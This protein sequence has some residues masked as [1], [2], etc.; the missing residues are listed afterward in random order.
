MT[1]KVTPM[2]RQYLE[3]KGKYPKFLLFYR[4]GDFYE[5]FNDDA[6]TASSI[7][8]ITLTQRRSSKDVEG[9]PMCG[10]PFH[11]AEGYIAKLVRNGF[12]VALCEQIES[13]EQAKK[14][15]G[16]SA[17]VKR[18]VVRLFTAGTLTEESM[19][20]PTENNYILSITKNG[21]DYYLAWL[22]I[23]AGSF[24]YSK[25]EYNDISAEISRIAPSEIV[26]SESLAEK[27][28]VDFPEIDYNKFTEKYN[29]YFN[30][31]RCEDLI[32][33]TY[34]V[35]TLQGFGI[36]NKGEIIAC[37]TLLQYIYET[38]MRD[39]E[40]LSR[41]TELKN[42]SILHIDAQSRANLEIMKTTRGEVR[43]SLF[44]AINHTLTPFGNRKLQEFLATPLQD[45]TLINH[46]LDAVEELLKKLLVKQ[47]LTDDLK[48][49]GDFER[50]LS[51]IAYDRASPRDLLVIKNSCKLFNPLADKLDQLD[52]QMFKYIASS[53]RGFDELSELLN[54]SILDE[55]LPL[56]ARDGG[57]IKQGFCADFDKYKSLSTNGLT[58]L[59]NL[60]ARESEEL[61]IP[62]LKVKYNKVWGYFIEV[63]KQY[64]SKIPER[65]VHR[66][67]TTNAMRFTTQELMD[68]EREIASSGSLALERELQLFK[69][70]TDA[71]MNIHGKLMKAAAGLAE[72]DVF[73][74]SATL[75][76]KKNYVRPELTT[77]LEF[78]IQKGRHPVIEKTVENFIPNDA[79]LSD[80]KL[81]LITGP[82]MAG[83]S[84]F[85]RQ[86][87]IITLMA[88]VGLF[89]PAQ[90]AKIGLV[91]RIFTR[92]GASDDLSKGQSTFMVEMVETAN[93]LNNA[94]ER[95][96]VILDEIGRG[97]ATFDGLSI[98]WG[99]VEH[100][101]KK[102]KSRG[103]FATHYHEL[104]VLE[105]SFDKIENH[106]V[107]VKEW[108]GEVV[109]LHEVGL[110][111]SPG[112]YGIHVAKIAGLPKMATTRAQKIL[113]TLE[114][115]RLIDANGRA[116]QQESSG[117]DLF[118]MADLSEPEVIV[119]VDEKAEKLKAMI[120]DIDVDDLTPRQA[121]DYLYSLKQEVK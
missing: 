38:Q 83:K 110:G 76:E 57:F 19:L 82:N 30:F 33:K 75:A 10:V 56:L 99:C 103:L 31:P 119:E 92:V 107:K 108:D 91:D 61:A 54:K 109:F 81:W 34:K 24:N 25:V 47:D 4:M 79:E 21:V 64:E 58:M 67:T 39:V 37:G 12:K 41:P 17:L 27:L 115:T 90:S 49:F 97:T 32:K 73:A 26:L 9:V 117:F 85:L 65:Y 36:A 44:D 86:N 5:L 42:N 101:V 50:S 48:L 88:H 40:G 3:L 35:D 112:S 84:T 69:L 116:V 77:G 96:F 11:A 102:N 43:G 45:L 95:S 28:I 118:A 1:A 98:A 78:D 8:G 52:G 94:T 53:L 60:E 23:S 114:S 59:R 80:S 72:F 106:H 89:V 18:D 93:I 71:V 46:R 68:L 13:P 14:E 100:L 66:Q 51:R 121:L 113:G 22:D 111:A 104:T 20:S 16:A 63:T 2:M 74:S 15:R 105:D 7:L 29:D 55:D 6:K 70:I 120:K 87:A 62:T